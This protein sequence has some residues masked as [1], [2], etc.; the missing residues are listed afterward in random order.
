V[1]IIIHCI[2]IVHNQPSIAEPRLL[3][4]MNEPAKPRLLYGMN[5]QA[6]PRLL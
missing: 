3:C 1:F 6:E 5:E 2:I 4:G